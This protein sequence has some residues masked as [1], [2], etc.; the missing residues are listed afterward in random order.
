MK[1]PSVRILLTIW[2]NAKKEWKERPITT[3]ISLF[4]FLSL[5]GLGIWL[6]H[7][8]RHAST[9]IKKTEEINI[10]PLILSLIS[11][12]ITFILI[13]RDRKRMTQI[14]L[15][16]V[17]QFKWKTEVYQ[18]AD[19]KVHPIPYCIIHDTRLIKHFHGDTAIYACPAEQGCKSTIKEI[20]LAVQQDKAHSLIEHKLKQK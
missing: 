17:D 14:S 3:S 2:N 20:R 6:P 4:V 12:V 15:I 10:F 16:Q 7:S 18:N 8:L 11:L 13:R 5:T 19:F 1:I 9:I